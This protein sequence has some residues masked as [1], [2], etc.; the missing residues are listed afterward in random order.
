MLGDNMEK[1]YC[2]VYRKGLLASEKEAYDFAFNEGR[3]AA[4]NEAR[5]EAIDEIK[6]GIDSLIRRNCTIEDIKNYIY[7]MEES[8]NKDLSN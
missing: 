4:R 1:W 8:K 6:N 2:D 7:K 5:N 3:N